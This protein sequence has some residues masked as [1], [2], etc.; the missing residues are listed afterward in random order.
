MAGRLAQDEAAVTVYMQ[1]G[2]APEGLGTLGVVGPLLVPGLSPS[3]GFRQLQRVR[4]GPSSDASSR[5]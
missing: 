3:W 4:V 5:K 1:G 2:E